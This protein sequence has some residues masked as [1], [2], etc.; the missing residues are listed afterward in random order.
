MR[1]QSACDYLVHTQH[2]TNQID[3]ASQHT[4]PVVRMAVLVDGGFGFAVR[5]IYQS[6]VPVGRGA[7]G[8]V[9]ALIE[10]NCAARGFEFWRTHGSFVRF[11]VRADVQEDAFV[12]NNAYF[13]RLEGSKVIPECSCADFLIVWL[14]NLLVSVFSL[15]GFMSQKCTHDNAG[16]DQEAARY[17]SVQ[18]QLPHKTGFPRN[19]VA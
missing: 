3:C 12:E 15:T 18:G 16:C 7:F 13:S 2:T 9:S 17:H 6:I 14:D 4:R 5:P 19:L 11:V 8:Y 1:V 10:L